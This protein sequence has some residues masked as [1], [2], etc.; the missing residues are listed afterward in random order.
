MINNEAFDQISTINNSGA[1]SWRKSVMCWYETPRL[2]P[3]TY[4]I[5]TWPLKDTLN[6]LKI[7]DLFAQS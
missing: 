2:M 3:G 4:G 5:R 1:A 6:G 7:C